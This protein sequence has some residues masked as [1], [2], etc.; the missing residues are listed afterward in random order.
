[1]W[2]NITINMHAL[3]RIGSARDVR[4]SGMVF[5]QQCEE[6]V[7]RVRIKPQPLPCQCEGFRSC[8]LLFLQPVAG[9]DVCV[10]E[11]DEILAVF[12][13]LKTELQRFF[14]WRLQL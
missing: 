5:V 1:M 13:G 7:G 11:A 10:A 3:E 9:L 4:T 6:M 14:R 2:A 12:I 8:R